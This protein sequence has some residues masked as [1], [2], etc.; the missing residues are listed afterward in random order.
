MAVRVPI[1]A[2]QSF[3]NYFA[4][5]AWHESLLRYG[6][7]TT[8]STTRVTLIGRNSVIDELSQLVIE[9]KNVAITG[10]AG[11]GKTAISIELMRRYAAHHG[12]KTYYLDANGITT[13]AQLYKQLAF[14]FHV[15]PIANEPVLLR[16]QMVLRNEQPYLLIDNAD[17]DDLQHMLPETLIN[18]IIVHFPSVRCLVTSRNVGVASKFVSYYERP[19]GPLQSDHIQSSACQLFMRIFAQAGGR[20]IEPEYVLESCRAVIGNPLLIG[21]IA[22]AA[23]LGPQSLPK[24]DFVE[25]TLSVLNPIEMRILGLLSLFTIPLYQPLFE[26]G[27]AASVW[28]IF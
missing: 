6:F 7:N 16:L 19:L 11:I 5:S 8:Q 25:R 22:N 15:K 27:G 17:G 1:S 26:H 23:A 9:R 20:H 12:Q 3:A 21:M 18:Q 4:Q 10:P 28:N 2:V 24:H 13:L 14:V